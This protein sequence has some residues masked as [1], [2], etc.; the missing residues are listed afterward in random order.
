M[1]TPNLP[2]SR[3]WGGLRENFKNLHIV[4]IQFFAFDN[5]HL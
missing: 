4:Q 1:Y 3:I 2:E 5:E